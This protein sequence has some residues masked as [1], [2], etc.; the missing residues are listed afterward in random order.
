MGNAPGRSRNR[1]RRRRPT[2]ACL[3]RSPLG[4]SPP[5]QVCPRAIFVSVMRQVGRSWVGEGGGMESTP[6]RPP[7]PRGLLRAPGY[8]ARRRGWRGVDRGVVGKA[9]SSSLPPRRV[10][11]SGRKQQRHSSSILGLGLCC[12]PYPVV[13]FPCRAVALRCLGGRVYCWQRGVSS[14]CAAWGP[15]LLG[16][17]RR[18][19]SSL[20]SVD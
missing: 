1:W 18:G 14:A 7:L 8:R 11:S 9:P 6:R 3:A 13:A 12:A 19:G 16:R 10:E 4:N 17:W 20:G 2:G 15:P 5:L